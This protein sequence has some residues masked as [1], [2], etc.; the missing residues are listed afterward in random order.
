M[1]SHSLTPAELDLL[2]E[3]LAMAASRKESMARSM[4]PLSG[5]HHEQRADAMRTLR[6]KLYDHLAVLQDDDTLMLDVAGL[7]DAAREKI[8]ADVRARQ[9]EASTAATAALR[10]RAS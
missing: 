5:R 9:A 1:T 6:A 8:V 7:S 4:T 10:R 3:A 2:L